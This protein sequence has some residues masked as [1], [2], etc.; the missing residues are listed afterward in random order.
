MTSKQPLWITPER[1]LALIRLFYKSRGF[2][3]YGHT[4]CLIPEHHYSVYIEYL[5]DDWKL[6]DRQQR[7]AEWEAESK[8][9]H[10]VGQR[11]Y[12]IEGRFNALSRDIFADNQP[13]FYLE[14][15]SVSGITLKP[16]VKV[17]IASSYIRLYVDLSGIFRQLSKSKRRKRLR[18]GKPFPRE[19]ESRINAVVLQAYRDYLT[20]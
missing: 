14:G 20:R 2:C 18:Y 16:F 8:A 12:P 17:R 4:L 1:K 9:L 10:S 3:I 11:M 19:V 5:I 7:L 13:L 15:Q 6:D